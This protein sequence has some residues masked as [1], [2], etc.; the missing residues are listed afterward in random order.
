MSFLVFSLQAQQHNVMR[1][2]VAFVFIASSIASHAQSDTSDIKK[3]FITLVR[4]DLFD[5]RLLKHDS[6]LV[7]VWRVAKFELSSVSESIISK[8]YAQGFTFKAPPMVSRYPLIVKKV[9]DSLDGLVGRL[10]GL[11]HP[12]KFPCLRI[13]NKIVLFTSGVC[14]GMIYGEAIG[15]RGIMCDN[16]HIELF[17]ESYTY[18]VT[19]DHAGK[20]S[21]YCGQV[22][23]N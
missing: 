1:L 2:L 7:I 5:K 22:A 6:D 13:S 8:N 12:E 17:G 19:R 3:H 23:N 11:Y 18:F 10:N 9:E 14:E 16:G 4:K 21:F 15:A 20:V